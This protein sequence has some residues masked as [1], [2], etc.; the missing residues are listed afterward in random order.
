AATPDES[1]RET[2]VRRFLLTHA[3][4]GLDDLRARYPIDP[5]EA[6]EL[7]ERWADA[8]RLVRLEPVEDSGG[9]LW[10]DR[11]NLDE[12]RRLSIALRRRE[13]VAV[14][15]EVFADFVARR[16][17]VHPE[18]RWEGQAAVGLVLEQLHGFAAPAEL[19]ESELLP[20][21]VRDYRASW[22]DDVLSSGGWL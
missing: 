13:S 18:T 9:P 16:Q 11:P 4:I 3:L 7:L 6:T 22:L 20:R 21:R 1:A 15:P 17:H 2:I 5:A 14:A 19:W 8:G 10:A 12:V